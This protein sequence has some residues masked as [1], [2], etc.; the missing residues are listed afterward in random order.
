[1]I[2]MKKIVDEAE[3]CRI[4]GDEEKSYVLYMK[5]LSLMTLVQKMPD[6][7][8]QKDFVSKSLGSN[9]AIK[10]YINHVEELQKSLKARYEV[11]YPNGVEPATPVVD[12]V[13]EV[14][15][16]QSPPVQET[17][18]CKTLKDMID[19]GKKLLIMDCRSQEHY[20]LTG[21][22]YQYTLNVPEEIIKLGMSASKIQEKLPN[23]SRVYWEMRTKRSYIILVDWYS[24]RFNRNSTVWHLREILTE[25][26]HDNDKKPW[27][28]LLEGGYDQYKMMYPMVCRNPHFVP[29]RESSFKVPA[30]GDIEYPSIGD[31]T[32]KDESFSNSIPM[33]DRAMKANAVSAYKNQKSQLELLNESSKLADQSIRVEEALLTLEKEMNQITKN[34]EN[35]GDSGKQ[36]QSYLFRIW[37]LGAKKNDTDGELKSLKKQI[38]EVMP[39]VLDQQIMTKVRQVEIELAEKDRKRRLVQEE[40]EK[41]KRERDEN[42]RI[43]RSKKPTLDNT[44]TP[45]KVSRRE[46]LILSP[47]SLTNNEIVTPSIPSFDRSSKPVQLAPRQIF[48]KEDFSP[49]YGNVVSC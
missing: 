5:Y 4:Q 28:L 49:V 38:D 10:K 32:M 34:K 3:K 44:R 13:A 24:T 36:E 47:K 42:L 8:K 35:D 6:F 21:L 17:I 1:M 7:Q 46:E 15:P 2:T 48:N 40:V 12:T 37:E 39:E 14:A 27:I 26:D 29:P 19:S 9:E 11:A 25:W 43:A 31:I 16:E 23:E 22:E 18:S 33:I 30:V 41:N 20:E 45:P